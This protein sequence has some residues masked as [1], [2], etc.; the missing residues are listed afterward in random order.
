M[1]FSPKLDHHLEGHARHVLQSVFHTQ[2]SYVCLRVQPRAARGIRVPGSAIRPRFSS[3]KPS[4]PRQFLGI[5]HRKFLD[6]G[7]TFRGQ[8]LTDDFV[9]VQRFHEESR[10]RIS[11]NRPGGVRILPARSGCRYPSRSAAKPGAHSGRDDR[12]QGIAG[13]SCRERQPRC[14]HDLHRARLSRLR[15]APARS[16]RKWRYPATTE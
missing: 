6:R 1:S 4:M 10:V 8:Q 15:P 5:D 2:F 9:D 13:Y 14:A 3:S 12:S 11:G 7:E 16:P